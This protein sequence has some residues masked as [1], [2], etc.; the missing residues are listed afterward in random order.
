MRYWRSDKAYEVK[1]ERRQRRLKN[2]G[3]AHHQG[4]RSLP[5][6]MDAWVCSFWY[7]WTHIALNLFTSNHVCVFL[8]QRD[9]HD[10][11]EI[12]VVVGYALSKKGKA[13][14]PNN[15]FDPQD[16]PE[17][18]TNAGVHPKLVE[19]NAAF[20]QRHGDDKDPT[21]EPLDPELVMR[22]GGGKQHGSYWM[23]NSAIDPTTTPTLREIRKSNS[24]SSSGIPIAP[25]QPSTTQMY[26]QMEVSVVPFVV[27]TRS[28]FASHTINHVRV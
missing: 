6:F 13:K 22:L 11:E 16:G 10:G 23:A 17:A 1:N 28:T 24:S 7:T 14:D 2:K 4:N 9:S 19:Y 21:T 25:R 27:H 18:Y 26:T 8:S 20:R 12:N 15:R 3:V 5:Q